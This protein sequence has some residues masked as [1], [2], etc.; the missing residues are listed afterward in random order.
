[1]VEKWQKIQQELEQWIQHC[2][3]LNEALSSNESHL[4]DWLIS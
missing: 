4:S 3:D 2:A 1:M